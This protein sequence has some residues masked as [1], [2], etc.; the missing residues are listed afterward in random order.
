MKIKPSVR[1][2]RSI[3]VVLFVLVSCSF[4]GCRPYNK[5][6]I[7][8]IEASQTAFLIPL[9]GDVVDQEVFKSEEA[10]NSAKVASKEITISK[11]WVQTGRFEDSGYYRATVKLVI[12]ERKP[13]TREW[14]SDSKTGTTPKNQVIMAESKESIGFSVGMNCSAQIDEFN[15]TKFLYRYNNKTLANI[16]DTEIRARVESKF[17]EE[18]AKYTLNNVLANKSVIMDSV[19]KDVVDYFSGRGIT[20]TVLGMKNGLTYQDAS[21]QKSINQKFSSEQNIITQQNKNKQILSKAK[22]DADAVIIKS[23]AEAT[24]NK[25]ISASIN[26]NLV[27]YKEIEKWNGSKVTVQGVSA[28]IKDK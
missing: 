3:L 20:I 24:A 8:T 18:C 5:P 4:M 21:I 26:D 15:A 25:K 14:T 13:E 16:M 27:K 12:V 23:S 17:V 7:K 1:I 2:R 22:A 28:I 10:L 6:E 9:T 11:R 19:R